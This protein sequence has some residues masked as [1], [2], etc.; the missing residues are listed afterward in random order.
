ML[1]SNNRFGRSFVFR[2]ISP[3][4][5]TGVYAMK[6]EAPETRQQRP[7]VLARV[8]SDELKLVSGAN[9]VVATKEPDGTKDITDWVHDDVPAN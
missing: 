5:E 6:K 2:A 3:T 8:L 7:R 4:E 1:F 9:Y